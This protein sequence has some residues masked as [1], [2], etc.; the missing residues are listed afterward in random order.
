MVRRMRQSFYQFP[1]E[2]L[3]KLWLDNG[4]TEQSASIVY[5]W[6]Y[7]KNRR[8][9]CTHHNLSG[10]TKAFMAANLD[11]DL[12]QIHT[13]KES[14]DQ[15]VK[16]LFEMGDGKRVESVLIPFQG[17]YSVCV[18][19]QVGC[20]VNCSFCFT[21]TQGFTRNLKTEEIIGQLLGV[22]TWLS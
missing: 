15:T 7:K 16:F 4:L 22:Q 14:P 13:V 11:F 6:H 20:A 1:Y 17:K 8:D 10:N 21:G 19:S 3:R 9:A 5:N 12:P 2:D 18:S